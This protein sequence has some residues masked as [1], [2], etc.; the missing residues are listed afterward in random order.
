MPMELC[1][2]RLFSMLHFF[3]MSL[4]VKF[5]IVLVKLLNVTCDCDSYFNLHQQKV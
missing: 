2:I 3:V 4:G 5:F 1:L